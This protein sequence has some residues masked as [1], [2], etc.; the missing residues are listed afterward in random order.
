[1]VIELATAGAAIK[2]GGKA[3]FEGADFDS[4][5]SAI[6]RGAL[7]GALS[8]ATAVLG[9][10][11][12]AAIFKVGEGAAAE[13]TGATLKQLV[14]EGIKGIDKQVLEDGSKEIMKNALAHGAKDINKSAIQELAKKAVS[15]ELTGEVREQAVQKLTQQLERDLK[16]SFRKETE[17]W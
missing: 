11:E 2:L 17:N 13:A 3:A 1:L 9:P 4:S 7:E 12:F 6:A 8:G 14:K 5:R 15:K 16:E 10:G